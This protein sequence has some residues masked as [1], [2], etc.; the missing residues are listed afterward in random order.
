MGSNGE[1]NNVYL[2]SYIEMVS[3]SWGTIL[4]VEALLIHNNLQTAAANA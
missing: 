1:A 4:D 2:V 3:N